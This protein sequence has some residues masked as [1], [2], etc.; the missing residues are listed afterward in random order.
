MAYANAWQTC[1]AHTDIG[2]HDE[3]LLDNAFIESCTMSAR[4]ALAGAKGRPGE[5]VSNR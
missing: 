2:N 5:K 4:S 3:F 1:L